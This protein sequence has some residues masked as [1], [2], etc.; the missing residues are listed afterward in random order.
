MLDRWFLSSRK[1][2]RNESAIHVSSTCIDSVQSKCWFQ[3]IATAFIVLLER[4]SWIR[5]LSLPSD[6]SPFSRVTKYRTLKFPLA[7]DQMSGHWAVRPGIQ[8]KTRSSTSFD[9]P[10]RREARSRSSGNHFTGVGLQGLFF[11]DPFEEGKSLLDRA[12]LPDLFS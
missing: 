9:H 1:R 8:P 11:E 2:G 10:T 6:I 3:I 4:Y 5:I 12:P 7:Q